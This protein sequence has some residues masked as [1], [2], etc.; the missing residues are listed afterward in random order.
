MVIEEELYGE[1]GRVRGNRRK[2]YGRK[3]KRNR[4][5]EKTGL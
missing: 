2:G 1:R 4:S 5:N 3:R